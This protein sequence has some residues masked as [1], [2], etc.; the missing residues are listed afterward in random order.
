[1]R[2][3]KDAVALGSA[4]WQQR[5]AELITEVPDVARSGADVTRAVSPAREAAK[6]WG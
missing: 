4:V 3:E 6:L 5:R 1:M 2:I